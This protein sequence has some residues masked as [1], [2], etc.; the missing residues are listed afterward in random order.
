MSGGK[1]LCARYG[2]VA[3]RLRGRRIELAD[4]CPDYLELEEFVKYIKIDGSSPLIALLGVRRGSATSYKAFGAAI[5][6]GQRAAGLLLARNPYP[7]VLPCHRVVRADGSLGGYSYGVELKRALLAYEGVEM[8]GGRVCRLAQVEE[9]D[10]VEEAL[11][12]SLGLGR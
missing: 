8:C 6:L 11:L 9:V 1:I 2:P 12:R 10:D 5:G 3:L 7:V 4:G